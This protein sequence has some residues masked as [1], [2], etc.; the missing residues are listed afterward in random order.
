VISPDWIVTGLGNPGGQYR[1]SRHN[2]GWDCLA[3]AVELGRFG[4]VVR[5]GKCQVCEGELGGAA[6]VLAWP[7]TYMNLSGKGVVALLGRY[8][9]D[10]S[11]LLVVHDDL[12]LPIGRLRLRKGGSAGGQNGV[13]SII[14]SLRTQDFYRL[15][16]GIGRPPADEDPVD[17]VLAAFSREQ[18]K[19][20]QQVLSEAASALKLFV[21]Q[22]PEAAMQQ[23]NGRQLVTP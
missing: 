18:H 15:R 6:V 11:S 17:Y 7:Q 10:A 12:D 3:R 5:Q 16:I 9:K 13:R 21:S 19:V 22:G 14:D 20:M 23:Y 4:R 2:T 1:H 8:G